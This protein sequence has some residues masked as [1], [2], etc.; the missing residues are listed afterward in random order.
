M[1]VNHLYQPSIKILVSSPY[2]IVQGVY[3][4]KTE[5]STHVCRKKTCVRGSGPG[6]G[7]I[8]LH[9]LRSLSDRW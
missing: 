7:Q 5:Y 1:M 2:K 3:W 6:K 9:S 4:E 8:R